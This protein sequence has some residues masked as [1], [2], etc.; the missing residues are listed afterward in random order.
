M[1]R[2]TDGKSITSCKK[3]GTRV[4]RRSLGTRKVREYFV[5]QLGYNRFTHIGYLGIRNTSS[6]VYLG[7]QGRWVCDDEAS[8]AQP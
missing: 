2:S 3:L 8:H 1:R 7:L 6:L 4:V 5:G